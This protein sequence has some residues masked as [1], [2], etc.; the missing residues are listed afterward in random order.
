MNAITIFWLILSVGCI[1]WYLAVL[2]Y[3]AIKGGHDIKEMLTK[4]AAAHED[5]DKE[6]V[7]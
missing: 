2:L 3:V 4:L 1:V 5:P 7:D 6:T